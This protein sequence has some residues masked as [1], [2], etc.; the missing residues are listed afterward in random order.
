MPSQDCEQ[1]VPDSPEMINLKC[2]VPNV[3]PQESRPRSDSSDQKSNVL[4][5]QNVTSSEHSFLR[6]CSK[7]RITTMYRAHLCPAPGRRLALRR[8]V[9]MKTTSQTYKASNHS[10][11]WRKFY[12][13]KQNTKE[14]SNLKCATSRITAKSIISLG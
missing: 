6:L 14:Q 3:L 5:S 1:S 2:V 9:W 13:T 11:Q 4:S 12:M 10:H 7:H 8:P